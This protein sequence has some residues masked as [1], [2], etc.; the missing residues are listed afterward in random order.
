MT[1]FFV[2]PDHHYDSYTDYWRLVELAGYEACTVG[3]M[4]AT[5][6]EHT[7]ILTMQ[8]LDAWQ[9]AGL[10]WP[11]AK[12][13]II[14]WDLEWRDKGYQG[15]VP[16]L[17]EFWTSDRHYAKLREYTFV[18]LGS[19]SRLVNVNPARRWTGN[20]LW[21]VCTLA[22]MGP[23]RRQSV[24]NEI[25][26]RQII[27]APNSAWGDE[28]EMQLELSRLMLHVHQFDE[29]LCVPA[30]RFAMAAAAALPLVSE[31]CA[32]PYPLEPGVDFIAAP[33]ADLPAIVENT[34]QSEGKTRQMVAILYD[35]MCN[36]YRFDRN[37]EKALS[38]EA[39]TA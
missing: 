17:H 2:R 10:G 14:Y 38:A 1:T 12:A 19:H 18:P 31:V 5:N 36:Q 4:D 24:V 37:V 16:G 13:R 29:Y 26:G 34:L 6:A 9:D 21:D 3:D 33:T 23:P 20:A 8:N 22:Y 30:Q 27:V 32:D 28:R 15:V 7:Y 11:D 35:K 25:E 39:V